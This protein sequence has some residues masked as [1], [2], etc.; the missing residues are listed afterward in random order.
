MPT[1]RS[2]SFTSA[3]ME[4]FDGRRDCHGQ[5]AGLCM[6]E[7]VDL[8]LI[9]DH[10]DGKRRIGI[11]PLAGPELDKVK[12]AA[13]D[14]DIDN[15]S[16]A[17]SL[18][19]RLWH[20]GLTPYV[21]KTRS[22]GWHIWI[23]FSAW[24]DAWKVRAVLRLI[25]EE[26]EAEIKE[27]NP[28]PIEIFP[29]QDHARY[30]KRLGNYIN[31]PLFGED[32]KT[33]RT[34]IYKGGVIDKDWHPVN[35]KTNREAQ[36][37][38]MIEINDLTSQKPRAY[39]EGKDDSPSRPIR[40]SFL[41]CAMLMM[42]SAAQEGQRNE[43]CFRLSIHF[44]RCG[45]SEPETTKLMEEWGGR[46]SPPMDAREVHSCIKSAFSPG[47]ANEGLGCEN[48]LI[49]PVC[50]KEECPVYRQNHP[51]VGAEDKEE[52]AD[53]D[54]HKIR[55]DYYD[56]KEGEFRFLRGPLSYLISDLVTPRGG[57]LKCLLIVERGG[58]TIYRSQINLNSETQRTKVETKLV[59]DYNL[60]A[61]IATDLMNVAGACIQKISKHRKEEIEDQHRKKQSYV[62]TEK[63]FDK[64][65]E[66]AKDHPFILRDMIEATSRAGLV[67]EKRNRCTLYLMFS[68]RKMDTPISGIGKGDS[69]SGKSF[70]AAKILEL[71]PDED[72]EEYTR[73]SA[74]ALEYGGEFSLQHKILFMREAPGAEE[75]EHALR[76]LISEKDLTISTV[77]KNE[78]GQHESV[79]KKI[80]GPTCFYTTT[81]SL[82]VHAENETRFLTVFADET[83][84]MTRACLEPI[85]WQAMHGPVSLPIAVIEDWKNFQRTLKTGQRVLIPY[86]KDLT[87]GF[88][89]RSLR[90]RRDFGRMIELIKGCAFVHQYHRRWD[91]G[92]DE[93]GNPQRIIVAS[94]ADYAIVKDLVEGSLMRTTMNIKPGQEEFLT[95][96]YDLIA[97]AK[98]RRSRG[99][100][101]Q[102]HI[103]FANEQDDENGDRLLVYVHSPLLR[104]TLGKT[105][106]AVYKLIKAL[107]EEGLVKLSQ[108][109]TPLRVTAGDVEFHEGSFMLPTVSPEE[110]FGRGYEQD[111]KDM[112]DPIEGPDFSD[113]YKET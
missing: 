32:A 35:V 55:L 104:R 65:V 51:E 44:K 27:V 23:F 82:E 60:E 80:Q 57:G 30:G 11:Y 18:A 16:L 66:W 90:S 38:E 92:Y 87:A 52:V 98:E 102:D 22:K 77:Q 25:L 28:P 88:P 81:T 91:V 110:L 53:A 4:L 3:F 42:R 83:E 43:W 84:E 73:V 10:L 45:F 19:K 59:N 33:G 50:A 20:H 46:C 75:S 111:R 103:S 31:L 107:E 78:A 86:A 112:Y 76:T 89:Y 14:L 62:L 85:A 7:D 15:Y 56:P 70:L 5:G 96:L 1:E 79:Q 61:G 34:C 71:I 108:V 48:P 64:A 26:C 99:Q 97:E 40:H 41:P 17:A 93:D 21:E 36:L 9:Q 49:L 109:K 29:K 67:R 74:H 39:E 12:F 68:T 101:Q 13:I 58:D 37:D 63:E 2:A 54:P 69:S 6:K 8:Q 95:T 105:Q 100:L 47:G 113:I 24:V 72:I 106:Q 94:V